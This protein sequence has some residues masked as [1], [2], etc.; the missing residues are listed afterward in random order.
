MWNIK[1]S[2][3]SRLTK[4]VLRDEHCWPLLKAGDLVCDPRT[5]NH[6]G[7]FTSWD[8]WKKKKK[9]KNLILRHVSIVN[10]SFRQYKLLKRGIQ[11]KGYMFQKWMRSWFR[12][13]NTFG[14][15]CRLWQKSPKSETTQEQETRPGMKARQEFSQHAASNTTI[16]TH[17]I[18][19]NEDFFKFFLIYHTFL[20]ITENKGGGCL[21]W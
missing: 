1:K 3:V 13:E 7:H 20:V 2:F 16:M 12:T 8:I 5:I 11:C 17:I 6:L 21:G 10:A 9:K 15:L 14:W 4:V 18:S 19:T